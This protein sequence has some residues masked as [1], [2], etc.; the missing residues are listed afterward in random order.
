MKAKEEESPSAL[1]KPVR[2]CKGNTNHHRRRYAEEP[3]PYRGPYQRDRDRI[4]DVVEMTVR[5]QDC[6]YSIELEQLD[7]EIRPDQF[8]FDQVPDDAGHLVAVEVGDRVLHLDFIHAANL[9]LRLLGEGA[10]RLTGRPLRADA[11]Y[12]IVPP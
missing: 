3:H 2:R 1:R 4:V 9:R 11:P 7:I 5:D 8:L 12:S 6:V 10:R